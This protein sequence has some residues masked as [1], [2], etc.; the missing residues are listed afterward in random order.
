MSISRKNRPRVRWR[1]GNIISVINNVFGE[2]KMSHTPGPWYL[3]GRSAYG[4]RIGTFEE[5]GI[6]N[7][8]ANPI[9]LVAALDDFSPT[10]FPKGCGLGNAQLIVAAPELLEALKQLREA[11][12]NEAGVNICTCNVVGQHE[13]SCPINKAEAAIA[14]AT[15]KGE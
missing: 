11:I 6:S 13:N 12:R 9:A 14:K 1:E 4:W 5:L 8:V 3:N 7:T 10:V 2:A 15:G